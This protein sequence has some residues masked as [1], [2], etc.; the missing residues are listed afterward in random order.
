MGLGGV[1]GQRGDASSLVTTGAGGLDIAPQV[2]DLQL[3]SHVGGH[4]FIGLREGEGCDGAAVRLVIHL[5]WR[6]VGS[7]KDINLALLAS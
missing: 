4:Y 5:D 7:N 2:P 1:R 6:S 3:T